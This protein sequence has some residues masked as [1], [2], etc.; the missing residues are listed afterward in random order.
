MAGLK[1]T[2]DG[3]DAAVHPCQIAD[4]RLEPSETVLQK[5]A[6]RLDRKENGEPKSHAIA[7]EQR[8]CIPTLQT[9][10]AVDR[11]NTEPLGD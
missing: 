10:R 1:D 11:Q 6:E 8:G 4:A 2:I 3:H 5:R 9:G 7:E